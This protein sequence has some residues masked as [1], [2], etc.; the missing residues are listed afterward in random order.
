MPPPS[1][2]HES[3]TLVY[4]I[5]PILLG[6]IGNRATYHTAPHQSWVPHSSGSV[7]NRRGLWKMGGGPG[8]HWFGPLG[9]LLRARLSLLVYL[10]MVQ[11]GWEAENDAMDGMGGGTRG[12]E[13]F[14]RFFYFLVSLNFAKINF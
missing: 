6:E 9:G 7:K 3:P 13:T 2:R 14:E 11:V 8:D 12:I 4:R 5:P 1:D 10:G